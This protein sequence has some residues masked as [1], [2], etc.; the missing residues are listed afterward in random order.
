MKSPETITQA[1]VQVVEQPFTKLELLS[2]QF[3]C[4]ESFFIKIY[5]DGAG[6]H[7]WAM[8]TYLDAKR[9]RLI[10]SLSASATTVQTDSFE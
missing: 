2:P 1:M 4:F 3:K 9:S 10:A 8:E 7:K 5:G 6:H